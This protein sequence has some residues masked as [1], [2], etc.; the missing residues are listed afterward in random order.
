MEDDT[1]EQELKQLP[2]RH[3][4]RLHPGP[5]PVRLKNGRRSVARR[6]LRAASHDVRFAGR[7]KL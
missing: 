5:R 4:R 6:L 1:E 3:R 7:R 2:W